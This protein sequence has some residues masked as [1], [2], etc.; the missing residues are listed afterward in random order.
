MSEVRGARCEFRTF[1]TMEG[2]LVPAVKWVVGGTLDEAFTRFCEDLRTEVGRRL[3]RE[4]VV[5]SERGVGDDLEGG[6]EERH[7]S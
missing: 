1:E 3:G 2:L 6:D 5:N 4:G 7:M